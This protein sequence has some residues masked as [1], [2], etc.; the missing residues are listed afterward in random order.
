MPSI[1]VI[2]SDVENGKT[3]LD[4]DNNKTFSDLVDK[5]CKKKCISKKKRNSL[6]FIFN[7]N[8]IS[9]SNKEKL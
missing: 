2:M 4:I 8:E 7:G 9:S 1:S 5:Y 6:K 3:T